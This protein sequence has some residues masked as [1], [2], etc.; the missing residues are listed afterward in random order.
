MTLLPPR[1]SLAALAALALILQTT[2]YALLVPAAV[3][4]GVAGGQDSTNSFGRRDFLKTAAVG[5]IGAGVGF[6][7]LGTP[8]E[9][10]MAAEPLLETC[11]CVCAVVL[12]VLVSNLQSVFASVEDTI[13]HRTVLS[14][15]HV[16]D[17]LL[18]LHL[19]QLIQRCRF[20]E[21]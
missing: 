3:H 1:L 13:L 18:R 4:M 21:V 12:L 9:R 7:A 5:L 8:V 6:G 11:E 14:L 15:D 10:T 19:V 16:R 20:D 17:G 2:T